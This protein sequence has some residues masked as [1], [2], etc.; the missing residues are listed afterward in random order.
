[1]KIIV[2]GSGHVGSAA[3]A[4]LQ[5]SHHVVAVSR[6]SEPSVDIGD[7]TSISALFDQAGVVD[8]VICAAGSVPWAPLEALTSEDYRAAFAGKVLSQLD[9]VRLA[10]PYVSDGGSI[11]LT[12]GILARAAV[13]TGAAAAMANGAVEAFVRGAAPEMPGRIR[14]NA[15][16]PTVLEEATGY[17]ATF[18]GFAPVPGALV[19]RAY[20][21]SVEGDET[22]KTF[23]VE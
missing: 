22:G 17:L 18:A 15:V 11:T 13:T 19:G 3:I 2:I 10:T 12:T 20:V 7:P 23:I 1:M 14:L 6:S 21:R 4:A 5:E 9:V 16:S 8:A